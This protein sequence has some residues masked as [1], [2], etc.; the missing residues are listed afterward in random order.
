[1]LLSDKP[2][3][4]LP[5]EETEKLHIRSDILPI[6]FVKVAPKT[7]RVYKDD[8]MLYSVHGGDVIPEIFYQG[9]AHAFRGSKR[10]SAEVQKRYAIEKDWGAN[11][12]AEGLAAELG[13]GGFWRINIARVLLDFGRFPG[14]TPLGADHMDRSAIN[15]P[16]AQALNFKLKRDL[17]EKIYD[18]IS[19]EIEKA[20]MGKLIKIGLHSYDHRNPTFSHY[21]GTIRPEASL[22]FR[23]ASFQL[24]KHMP[25]GLFDPLFP[26]QLAE[27]TADRKLTSR[28]SLVLEK[29]GVAVSNNFPYLLPDG[30]VEVRSQIWSFFKYLQSV[31]KE[32]YPEHQDDPTYDLVWAML[33]DTNLR[34]SESEAL[35]SYIHMYRNPPK[36]RHK[37][38]RA[39][40]HAYEA[41]KGFFEENST[42]LIDRFRFSRHRL[43]TMA[44]EVRKD[45]IWNFHDDHTWDPYLGEEGPKRENIR[46][47]TALIAQAL[48]IYMQ[49]DR[50]N[51]VRSLWS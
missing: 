35:R 4:G 42:E 31:H 43:S 2:L 14:I 10:R 15:Y 46:N 21:Q 41:I 34:C 24:L 29:G 16:F 5:A 9:I 12:I 7:D 50:T 20:T 51:Q 48:D 1:M 11:Q 37:V 44:L 28:V 36:G 25:H 27:Y 6:E 23:S 32:A 17:L 45:L 8:I 40:Q 19:A 38:F 30:S 13:C 18:G 49:E 26:D 22:I 47:L 33:L 39:A 3:A